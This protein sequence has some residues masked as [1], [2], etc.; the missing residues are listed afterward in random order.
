MKIGKEYLYFLELSTNEIYEIHMILKIFL[1][2]SDF[3]GL[4][5]KE[6]IEKIDEIEKHI[7]KAIEDYD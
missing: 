2:N 4:I 5:S 7:K 6:R 1:G 3:H